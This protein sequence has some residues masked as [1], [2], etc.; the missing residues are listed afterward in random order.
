MQ[1]QGTAMV[2]Y[3]PSDVH[4]PGRVGDTITHE[5]NI[6]LAGV[7]SLSML[8]SHNITLQG[9]DAAM[10]MVHEP[11][12]SLTDLL[13]QLLSG[14]TKITISYIP[15]EEGNH[16]AELLFDASFLGVLVPVQ[17]TLPLTGVAVQPPALISAN[18]AMGSA[19]RIQQLGDAFTIELMFNKEVSVNKT[20]TIISAD[21]GYTAVLKRGGTPNSVNLEAV[22]R[23]P[24]SGGPNFNMVIPAGFVTD[25][26]NNHNDPLNLNFKVCANPYLVSS[27]PDN[28]STILLD[29]STGTMT[30]T[31][32]FNKNIALTND[33]P[34]VQLSNISF[35][36]DSYRINGNVLTFTVSGNVTSRQTFSVTIPAGAIADS[37]AL[38]LQYGGGTWTYNAMR[39]TAAPNI[40]GTESLD[41]GSESYYSTTGVR[42]NRQTI[43]PGSI[44]IKKTVFDDG[45][46]I[47]NSHIQLIR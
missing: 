32:T 35:N 24:T 9:S 19:V 23:T 34:P 11:S 14:G 25:S 45:S 39:R 31:Y 17:G 6:R 43:R 30:F 7:S 16:K 37:G 41:T 18:S 29:S 15:T 40:T 2:Q 47:T 4:F 22:S 36:L 12:L 44:Y 13:K 28:G 46:V 33:N 3:T 5:V 20:G 42:V 1:A 8:T 38:I 21:G 27:N 26:A 10:F